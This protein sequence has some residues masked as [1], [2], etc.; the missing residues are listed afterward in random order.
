MPRCDGLGARLHDSDACIAA[1]ARFALEGGIVR[2][3]KNVGNMASAIKQPAQ[4][5]QSGT[6]NAVFEDDALM[7]LADPC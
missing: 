6:C 4:N 3:Q 5:L 7:G 1:Q 2:T